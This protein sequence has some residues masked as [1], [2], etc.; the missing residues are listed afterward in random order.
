MDPVHRDRFSEEMIV[1]PK[2]A[3]KSECQ[4]QDSFQAPEAKT[5]HILSVRTRWEKQITE[6]IIHFGYRA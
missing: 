1:L 5:V 6:D 3:R 4:V 2:P